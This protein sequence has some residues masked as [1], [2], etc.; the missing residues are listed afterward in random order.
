MFV[1]HFKTTPT[2]TAR[3]ARETKH[4]A[5]QRPACAMP[6]SLAL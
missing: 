2:M 1:S 6:L 4:Q 5:H 3:P